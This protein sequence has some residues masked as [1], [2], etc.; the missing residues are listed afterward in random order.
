MS[1]PA[2]GP[3]CTGTLR[4]YIERKTAAVKRVKIGAKKYRV[5][6]GKKAVIRVKVTRKYRRYLRKRGTA[7]AIAIAGKRAARFKIKA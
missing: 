4:V 1:C 5:A 6:A 3:A 7:R 2:G